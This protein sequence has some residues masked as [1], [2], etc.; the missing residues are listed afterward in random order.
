[1]KVN[2]VGGHQLSVFKKG[3]LDEFFEVYSSKE[4]TANVLSFAEV[5]DMFTIIHSALTRH[6]L[7]FHRHGK[8]YVT[9]W[10]MEKGTYAT[11]QEMELSY[12]EA[13]IKKENQHMS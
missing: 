9:R 5:E 13:E 7:E 10:N 2:G 3:Y 12:T 11:A 8:L 4:T 1:M 6:S